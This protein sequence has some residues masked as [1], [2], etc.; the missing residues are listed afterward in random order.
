MTDPIKRDGFVLEIFDQC[1][2]KVGVEV[3]LQENV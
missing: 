1:A 3:I 2:F